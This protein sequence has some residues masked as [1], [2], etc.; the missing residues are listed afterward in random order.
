MKAIAHIFFALL[1]IGF[2]A[3]EESAD[4]PDPGTNQANGNGNG[5]PNPNPSPTNPDWLVPIEEVLD[6]GP[7]KDGIPS[8][9]D[10]QFT[11]ALNAASFLA[12]HDLVVGIKIGDQTKAYP[13]LILDWHEIVNDS[14]NGQYFS[15]NYCPLT[16]TAFAW[17]RNIKGNVTTFGVS[18]LLYNSNLIPYDRETDSEWSQ[19]LLTS[20]HG[21]NKGEEAEL[22]QVIETS[23]RTWRQMY[24]NTQVMNT[25]TGF[26]RRYGLYPYGDYLTNNSLIFPVN[27]LNDLYHKK[28]RFLGVLQGQFLKAYRFSAVNHS[29]IEVRPDI[30]AGVP[31][32][33]VGSDSKN[34]LVAYQSKLEDGTELNFTAV[35]NELPVVMKDQEGNKWDVFGEAVSGPRQGTRLVKMKQSI[36][37][38]FALAAFYPNPEVFR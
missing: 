5:N 24:P 4:V 16:G 23:W 2:I 36:G 19:L 34:F 31:L 21:E 6:G 3:C 32:V 15:L 26:E 10:P 1:L 7:G 28:E 22:I 9:D 18:G 35:Q 33:I 8:I 14:L 17:N 29:P 20:I 13:H 27:P 25:N 38:W 30:F 11:D 12:D 37:F